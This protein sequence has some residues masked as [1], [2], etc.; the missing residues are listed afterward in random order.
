MILK[1]ILESLRIFFSL[2]IVKSEWKKNILGYIQLRS[3]TIK[4]RKIFH[5]NLITDQ[6][7]IPFNTILT[8]YLQQFNR[9]MTEKKHGK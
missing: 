1:L 9:G 3:V 7:K 8:N 2:T 5:S 6:K 4:C